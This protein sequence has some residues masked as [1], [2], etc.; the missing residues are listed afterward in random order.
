MLNNAKKR[1]II[2][3]VIAIGLLA[4]AF[5]ILCAIFKARNINLDIPIITFGISALGVVIA[6]LLNGRFVEYAFPFG[7]F[8]GTLLGVIF[9]HDYIG[10]GGETHNSLWE[11]F[12][13][14]LLI[15]AALG[16]VLQV[17]RAV[18]KRLQSK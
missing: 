1:L 2:H 18:K 7:Y 11:I 12:V 15:C 13:G 16:I 14:T 3:G 9:E 10:Y 6:A 5:G 17:V 8:L 4:V